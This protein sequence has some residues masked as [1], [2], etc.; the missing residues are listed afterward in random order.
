MRFSTLS[1]FPEQI[2]ASLELSIGKKVLERNLFEVYYGQIRDKSINAYGKV[3][4]KL[5]GGGTGMLMMAEPIYESL[6]EARNKFTETHADLELKE[7]VIYMSPRGQVLT[8]DLAKN[9]LEY[10][11]LIIISGHYEGVDQRV[12]DEVGA[13][14]ISIGDYVLSGGELA[15]AVLIDAVMR[16]IPEVLPNPDAWEQDSHASGFLE[17]DQ[18]TRPAVWKD[19]QVPE[20]LLSGHQA[21]LEAYRKNSSILNTLKNRPDL[22]KGKRLGEESWFKF[23]DFLNNKE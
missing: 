10:N 3:D 11:H 20:V 14:E 4:D 1:L 15:S 23:I 19:R 5:Y 2:K 22:L 6:I 8:Q 12:L 9:L 13:D 17:E 7:K 21:N 18:Y 16:M